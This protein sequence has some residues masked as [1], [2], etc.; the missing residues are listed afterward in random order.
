MGLYGVQEYR[1]EVQNH[2]DRKME[3]GIYIYIYIH[4]HIKY[5]VVYICIYG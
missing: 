2:I 1:V 4:T 3:R 5:Y